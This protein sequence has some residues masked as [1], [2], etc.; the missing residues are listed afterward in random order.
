MWPV[1]CIRGNDVC[2]CENCLFF[3][4]CRLFLWPYCFGTMEMLFV[5]AAIVFVF[6]TMLSV[7]LWQ[8]YLFLWKF[9]FFFILLKW[10]FFLWKCCMIVLMETLHDCSCGN[11]DWSCDN[12][13]LLFLCKRRMIFLVE[14]LIDLVTMLFVFFF[15]M[16]FVFFRKRCLLLW[17]CWLFLWQCS[18]LLQYCLFLSPI[19]CSCGRLFV[20]VAG[21]LFLLQC[22]L[23]VCLPRL[24]VLL[25][26]RFLLNSCGVF[27][28]GRNCNCIRIHKVIY[29][30]LINLF[31]SNSIWK[32]GDC[33]KIQILFRHFI[34][35]GFK[36]IS[37]HLHNL[38]ST[39]NIK[40]ISFPIRSPCGAW[41]PMH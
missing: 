34:L 9:L 10:C 14:M 29:K 12:V 7:F 37:S 21:Y 32:K 24:F 3:R 33:N 27:S 31:L 18:F 13:A 20:L 16:L 36:M 1:V 26:F 40:N 30:Y 38:T 22:L 17:K 39:F 4:Q 15:K 25:P 23:S 28:T 35:I 8:F 19:I 41:N 6:A 11:S 2:F 5:L